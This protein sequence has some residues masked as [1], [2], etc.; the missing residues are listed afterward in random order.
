MGR[1]NPGAPYLPG[2]G[3]CGLARER[4]PLPQLASRPASRIRARLQSC[5]KDAPTMWALAPERCHISPG[6]SAL[7]GHGFSRA[8]PLPMLNWALAPEG[9]ITPRYSTFTCISVKAS[10][11]FRIRARLQSCRTSPIMP[12]ALAPERC[13]ISPGVPALKG[14]GFSRAEPLPMLNWALAPEGRITPRYSTFTCISVKASLMFRIRARLQSCRTNSK[15]FR[16][17]APERCH[18]SPGVSALKGHGFSRAERPPIMIWA[19]APE[20]RS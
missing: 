15:R 7:K 13:H 12:W 5:R 1:T 14:H 19:L 10:L 18:I 9:R 20:S 3:R 4:P 8:E 6:V 11:M 17:L 2:F 16:A